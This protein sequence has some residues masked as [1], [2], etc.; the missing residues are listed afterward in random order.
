MGRELGG[1][2]HLAE[3]MAI[4]VSKKRACVSLLVESSAGS[5]LGRVSST[6][7][8]TSSSPSETV[9]SRCGASLA[10]MTG[11]DTAAAMVLIRQQC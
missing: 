6:R 9:T 7:P 5:A 1:K 4:Q 3:A 2:S 8:S 11:V 10:A